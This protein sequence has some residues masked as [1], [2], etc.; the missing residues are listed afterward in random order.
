MG[1]SPSRAEIDGCSCYIGTPLPTEAAGSWSLP[2]PG[3][4]TSLDG[5]PTSS[6]IARRV[7]GLLGSCLP[8]FHNWSFQHCAHSMPP[9]LRLMSHKHQST[10]PNFAL[11]MSRLSVGA[12][13][14]EKSKKPKYGIGTVRC[15]IAGFMSF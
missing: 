12:F 6:I 10:R 3:G 11:E 4:L 9:P 14:F 7:P 1:S 8:Q 2:T 13:R 15:D 5:C